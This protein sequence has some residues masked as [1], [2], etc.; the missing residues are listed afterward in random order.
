MTASVIVGVRYYND[1]HEAIVGVSIMVFLVCTVSLALTVGSNVMGYRYER[2]RAAIEQS[3][4]NNP[5]RIDG[6][7]D[8]IMFN[9]CLAECKHD[10][11]HWF[12]SSTVTDECKSVEP[13]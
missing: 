2:R 5:H 3:L 13:L 9:T 10:A 1:C 12:W 6:L 8:I 4:E 11:D 7:H